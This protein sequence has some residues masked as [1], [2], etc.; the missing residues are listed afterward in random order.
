MEKPAGGFELEA[1]TGWRAWRFGWW[2][3]RFV[4]YLDDRE[5][6]GFIMCG[7]A[8]GT[9]IG[10]LAAFAVIALTG[11]GES[12]QDCDTRTISI[13]SVTILTSSLVST[14]LT[15]EGVVNAIFAP[16]MG[17]LVDATSWRTQIFRI[18]LVT[19]AVFVAIAGLTLFGEGSIAALIIFAAALILISLSYDAFAILHAAYVPELSKTELGRTQ[20]VAKMYVLLNGNQL[21]FVIIAIGLGLA[22]GF[23]DDKIVAPQVAALIAVLMWAFWAVPGMWFMENRPKTEEAKIKA[24]FLGI[25]RVLTLIWFCLNK[26][27]Q[28]GLYM[29]QYST[30]V[31]AASAIVG[32]ASGYLLSEVG[33]GSFVVQVVTGIVLFMTVPGAYLVTKLAKKV[34]DL[35]KLNLLIIIAWIFAV[36]LAPFLMRGQD[37]SPETI[38]D[39]F[40]SAA[41]SEVLAREP[42][43]LASVMVYIFAAVWGFLIG[44]IFP[45]Q[46]AL[47]SEIVPAGQETSFM[48]LRT[49][50]SKIFAWAPPLLYTVINETA[51]KD[52]KRFALLSITPFQVVGLFFLWLM[53]LEKATEEIED[54]LHLRHKNQ[55]ALRLEA[56]EGKV[57]VNDGLEI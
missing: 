45:A 18:L 6:T 56:I 48:G 2:N 55:A 57:A 50:A 10:Y 34:G 54:T 47:F 46:L 3:W 15:I 28:I 27:N 44:C 14:A 31:T 30:A 39:E 26:Y 23:A 8:R 42:T 5:R 12:V 24:G 37:A 1:E 4:R 21:V 51:G 25:P 40:C 53:S 33:F 22:L 32:L 38:N 35:R 13:G 20:I 11:L 19:V 43:G 16:V 52:E 9:M 49:F 29:I 36:G 7:T 17:V 41:E